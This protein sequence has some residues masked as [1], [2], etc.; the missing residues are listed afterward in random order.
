MQID[1]ANRLQELKAKISA[2]SGPWTQALTKE[3]RQEYTDL[4]AALER[5]TETMLPRAYVLG[6]IDDLYFKIKDGDL[7]VH[8]L[9]AKREVQQYV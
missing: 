7:R 1:Q 6:I 2:Q 3:E 9:A 8:I 5:E 4:K